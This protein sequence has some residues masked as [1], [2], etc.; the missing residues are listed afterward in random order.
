MREKL[1]VV[2]PVTQL[3]PDGVLKRWAQQLPF[4]GC[5]RGKSAW[6]Y[7]GHGP[8]SCLTGRH[9]TAQCPLAGRSK[10]ARYCMQN[11]DCFAPPWVQVYGQ[12]S[13]LT[14][15]PCLG[16]GACRQ[17]ASFGWPCGAAAW[18]VAVA[19]QNPPMVGRLLVQA[20]T[21]TPRGWWRGIWGS[22]GDGRRWS[23]PADL[24]WEPL[25]RVDCHGIAESPVLP[26][27]AVHNLLGI[28]DRHLNDVIED[29]LFLV[30]A[31]HCAL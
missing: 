25:A 9:W 29:E 24:D 13:G 8:Q 1:L 2:P 11:S 22:T 17:Q 28:A 10:G 14:W 27:L 20:G 16:L 12:H 7:R 3:P 30:W 31:C 26:P 5:T 18:W 19:H 23:R 15:T 6:C 4:F 21:C